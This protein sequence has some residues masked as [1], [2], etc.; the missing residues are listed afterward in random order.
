MP[1]LPT[2]STIM[3]F[4]RDL[5]K[6]Q[7]FYSALGI[8]WLGG[9]EE[10]IGESGLPVSTEKCPPPYG[11]GPGI[12]TAGL[13]DLWGDF[14]EVEFWFYLHKSLH[15]AAD[16]PHVRIGIKVEDPEKVVE[17]LKAIG[18]YSPDLRGPMGSKYL[19]IDPDGRNIH[20]LGI[21][22]WH[23]WGDLKDDLA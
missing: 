18:L 7:E 12:E 19:L 16:A 2:V 15:A 11:G 13:P 1:K 23:C 21:C 4:T 8:S 9:G 14:G 3:L 22:G 6:V 5:G 10:P 17:N 20:L